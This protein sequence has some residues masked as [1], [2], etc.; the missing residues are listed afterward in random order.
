MRG[1]K[2]FLMGRKTEEDLPEPGVLRGTPS[3][4]REI[5]LK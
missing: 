2:I 4:P 1:G 3:P 5:S